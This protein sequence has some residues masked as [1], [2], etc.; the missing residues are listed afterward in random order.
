MRTLFSFILICLALTV[1]SQDSLKPAYSQALEERSSL[2]QNFAD[3]KTAIDTSNAALMQFAGTAQS[4]V[5]IDDT[6]IGNYLMAETR[7]AEAAQKKAGD[8]Q[9]EVTNLKATAEANNLIFMAALGGSGLFLI[10][11]IIMLVMFMG[12]GKK[13]KTAIA[14]VAEKEELLAAQEGKIAETEN[15]CKVKTEQIQKESDAVK[16]TAEQDKRNFKMKEE[17]YLSQVKLIEE[18]IKKATQ[19]EADLNYQV[20]QLEL[21]LK[22]ELEGTVREK[23]ALENKVV[24]LERELSDARMRLNEM[25]DFRP[26]N[27][28]V[29]GLKKAL[30]DA[31]NKL[32]A[33]QNEIEN[34]SAQQAPVGNP[35][36]E[37][38]KGKVS[39]YENE[40][41]YLRQC[42]ENEKNAKE[43]AQQ[44]LSTLSGDAEGLMRDRDELWNRIHGM[45]SHIGELQQTINGLGFQMEDLNNE[46]RH[47]EERLAGFE[48]GSGQNPDN[49]INELIQEKEQ[50]E[51]ELNEVRPRAEEAERLRTELQELMQFMERFRK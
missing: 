44:A 43:Q 23:C 40:A 49:R 19:K 27:T 14:Q 38:L 21:K 8:L 36:Y 13:V 28:E 30:E 46:K 50:L 48:N 25:K 20:F 17:E 2:H 18:K 5:T 32:A 29:D 22:N 31:N 41:I 4:L 33:L 9:L 3:A 11:F 6:L 51:R 12:R 35:D 10:L 1:F 42:I 24:D 37:D 39:W 34:L 45:E 26:D 7:R 16:A 47:L 15:A